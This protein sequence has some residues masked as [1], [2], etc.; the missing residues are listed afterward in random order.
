VSG[1]VA[2]KESASG[3]KLFLDEVILGL[4]QLQHNNQPQMFSFF[5]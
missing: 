2:T 4:D 3:V 5:W 1:V